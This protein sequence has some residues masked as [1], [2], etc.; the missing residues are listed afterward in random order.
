MTEEKSP[1]LTPG[2]RVLVMH[3][4]R[5][6]GT[7]TVVGFVGTWMGPMVEVEFDDNRGRGLLESEELRVLEDA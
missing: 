4:L 3:G 5:K 2:T 1:R 6:Q 7:G